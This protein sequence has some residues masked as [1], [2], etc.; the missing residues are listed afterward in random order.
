M[1]NTFDYMVIEVLQR[2][3]RYYAKCCSSLGQDNRGKS[4]WQNEDRK[5]KERV[6]RITKDLLQRGN[7]TNVPTREVLEDL[8][9]ST[10]ERSP[11]K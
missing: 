9:R 5:L 11:E 2:G 10:E 1:N 4:R 8:L 7:S 3:M 6:K